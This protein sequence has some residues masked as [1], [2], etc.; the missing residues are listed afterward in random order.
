[1]ISMAN[2]QWRYNSPAHFHLA[3]QFLLYRTYIEQGKSIGFV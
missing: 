1:M 3:G 2:K